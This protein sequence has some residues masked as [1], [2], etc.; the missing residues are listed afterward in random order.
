MLKIR[1]F[2]IILI[3]LFV[4]SLSSPVF[5]DGMI[6]RY[7]EDLWRLQQEDNQL[8]AINYENGTQNMLLAVGMS[9]LKGEK[10][11]WMFP[12]PAKAEEVE[13]D[14]IQGF[15][16]LTG[17][18]ARNAKQDKFNNIFIISAL[19]QV[20]TL[21][22]GFLFLL[23][24]STMTGLSAEDSFG[25]RTGIT[26]L[27]IHEHIE[28]M[29][30]TTELVSANEHGVFYSYLQINGF[31]LPITSKTIL[32]EY[33]DKGYSFV[34]TWVSDVEEFNK[35]IPEQTQ[36][37]GEP[38]NTLGVFV[39][40]P[41]EK[42]FF[43][44]KPTKVYGEAEV[45]VLL[46]VMSHVTPKIYGDIESD[47]SIEYLV[48]NN[49]RV[50]GNYDSQQAIKD[51]FNG[52]ESISDLKYTKII[53]ETKSKNFTDDLW[54]ENKAPLNITFYDFVIDN[55]LFVGVIIFAIIS[56][57]SSLFAGLVVF[58]ND[59]PNLLIFG[60]FGLTNFLTLIGF[61]LLAY[62]LKIDSGFAQAKKETRK[63]IS[64]LGAILRGIIAGLVISFIISILLIL[65]SLVILS[66]T[67]ILYML[68]PLA[69]IFLFTTG[70]VTIFTSPFIWGYYNK[71]KTTKFIVLFTATFTI[72]NLIFVFLSTLL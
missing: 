42:I 29:G 6:Y 44:L 9:D 3:S 35:L 46:Y 71:G 38:Q 58:R 33:T 43:P 10:A 40:F 70:F 14:I 2:T 8:S 48:Q 56:M 21:P 19:S 68:M 72:L 47:T 1:I 28:E 11:V 49:Y 64:I 27:T 7:D 22:L 23:T 53:I 15:P 31:E 60:L 5:A 37:R 26:G 67:N 45:P 59:K 12:V 63:G 55:W 34:V 69:M 39:K 41:T 32:D 13:L 20:Y 61:T 30:L 65:P 54:I 18:S 50:R 62:Y 51:F 52:K 36:Y 57:I 25:M 16:Y 17:K 66:S 4:F 24:S